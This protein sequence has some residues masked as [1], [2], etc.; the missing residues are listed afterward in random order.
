MTT[1]FIGNDR[2]GGRRDDFEDRS[3]NGSASSGYGG[4]RSGGGYRGN[5]RNDR[6]GGDWSRFN[7][8]GGGGGGSSGGGGS[9]WQEGGGRDG[10]R[11]LFYLTF[12]HFF[13]FK[14]LIYVFTIIEIIEEVVGTSQVHLIKIGQNHYPLMSVWKKNCLET[15][16]QALTLINMKTFQLK[17]L[18]KMFHLTLIQ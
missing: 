11:F 3:Y 10:R 6:E 15:V 2:R 14:I 13:F 9:R 16:V 7:Q 1:M 18:V 8:G 5:Y 4:G 17:Q 12:K